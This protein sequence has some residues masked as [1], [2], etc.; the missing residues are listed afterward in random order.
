ML[1]VVG[2]RRRLYSNC[3]A[4]LPV[5]GGGPREEV[6]VIRIYKLGGESPHSGHSVCPPDP[7]SRLGRERGLGPDG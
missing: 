6:G 3:R 4:W 5:L 7:A 1:E 2:A